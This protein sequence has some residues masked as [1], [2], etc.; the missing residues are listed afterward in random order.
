MAAS[1]DTVTPSKLV[2]HLL[3]AWVPTEGSTSKGAISV[4]EMCV[5]LE[6]HHRMGVR[7]VIVGSA[8]VRMGTC[9]KQLIA[10]VEGM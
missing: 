9:S 3:A 2:H 10:P 5:P 6:E 1:H 4:H 8:S 7:A